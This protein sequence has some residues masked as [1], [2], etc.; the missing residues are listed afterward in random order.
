MND[1][2]PSPGATAPEKGSL[3]VA[4]MVSAPIACAITVGVPSVGFALFAALSTPGGSPWM[5]LGAPIFATLFAVPFALVTGWL[6]GFPITLAIW[7]PQYLLLRRMGLDGRNSMLICGAITG[8][9]AM[10]LLTQTPLPS[11]PMVTDLPSAWRTLWFATT[12]VL[13]AYFFWLIRRPDRDLT[14]RANPTTPAP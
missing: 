1:L 4:L 6:F 13:A 5:I 11:P 12:G 7:L 8:V 9:L 2:P 14:Q 10:L 3:I